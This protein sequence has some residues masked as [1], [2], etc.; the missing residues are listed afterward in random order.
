MSTEAQIKANRENAQKSTGP[1]TAEGK[2]V[3]SQN[4]V[5]HGLLSCQAAISGKPR[6]A[7]R[8]FMQKKANLQWPKKAQSLF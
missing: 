8:L 1:K 4:V 5:K 6:R 7:A 2:T 3:V